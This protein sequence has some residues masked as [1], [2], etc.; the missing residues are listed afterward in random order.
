MTDV[1]ATDAR[2]DDVR[3]DEYRDTRYRRPQADRSTTSLLSDLFTEATSMFRNEARL[4]SR[5]M[6]NKI[7]QVISGLMMIIGGAVLVIPA[8]VIL[9]EAI[10]VALENN[11]EL[12]AGW[13]AFIVGGITALIALILIYSGS[14]A[15]KPDSLAPERTIRQVEKDARTIRERV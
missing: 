5:E 14:K 9:L 8:L 4:A 6:S 3:A 7:D 11:T 13:S 2:R 10:V 12:S 1:T 15:I